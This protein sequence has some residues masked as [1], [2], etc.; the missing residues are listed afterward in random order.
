M[1]SLFQIRKARRSDVAAIVAMFGEDEVGHGDQEGGRDLSPY[2]A[3]F[4]RI[5]ASPDNAVYVAELDGEVV[6][7]FQRTLIPGLVAHG[8]IRLKIESVHVRKDKRG[9]GLGKAMMRFA[10]D[11]ARELGAGIVELTSNKARR[12]A[13]RFY[14]RLGFTRSHEGFKLI[15]ATGTA[16]VPPAR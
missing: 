1:S 14:E 6:G 11:E 7:T 3:G 13:H 9:H 2:L 4:E 12:D 5:E 16:G 10:L 15:L 8:R